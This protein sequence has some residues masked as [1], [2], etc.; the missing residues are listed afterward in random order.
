MPEG[1][2]RFEVKS[3]AAE[4]RAL[5]N[6]DCML[7]LHDGMPLRASRNCADSR[8]AALLPVRPGAP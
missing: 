7:R 3:G 8:R 5:S 6:R 2:G 1:G 4:L